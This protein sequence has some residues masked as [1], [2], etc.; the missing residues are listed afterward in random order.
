MCRSKQKAICKMISEPL[1]QVHART[2]PKKSAA[3]NNQR[4]PQFL[5]MRLISPSFKKGVYLQYRISKQCSNHTKVLWSNPVKHM[6][7]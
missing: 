1:M 3:V 6:S 7:A 5:L 2:K 4:R